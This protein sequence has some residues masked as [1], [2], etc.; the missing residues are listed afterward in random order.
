MCEHSYIKVIRLRKMLK[1]NQDILTKIAS[2]DTTTAAT[3]NKTASAAS[4]DITAGA[5]SAGNSRD[6]PSKKSSTLSMGAAAK[7]KIKS[8]TNVD[9]S[10]FE[11]QAKNFDIE[12]APTLKD[13]K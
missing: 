1:Q 12:K 11:K 6:P 2:T 13:C 10:R 7:L 5:G 4:D 9:F 3:A 8:P